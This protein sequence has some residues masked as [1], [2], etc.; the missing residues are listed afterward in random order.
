MPR[1]TL[2]PA[3]PVPTAPPTTLPKDLAVLAQTDPIWA[4]NLQILRRQWKW[5]AFSQF[6]YTFAHLLAMHDVTLVD[7]EDDLARSTSLYLPRVMT[8]L[9]YTLSQD[10]KV[11]IDNWQTALRKQYMKRDPDANPIGPEP[12]RLSRQSSPE[13][14]VQE[15][16]KDEESS[17]APARESSAVG[18]GEEDAAGEPDEGQDES[19]TDAIKAESTAPEGDTSQVKEEPP[20]EQ[21]SPNE[22][23]GAVEEQAQEES[24]DWLELSMLEKLDSLHLLTEWQFQT[25]LRLRQIM[26]DDD[27][28]AK[29]RIEPIGYDAKTNA[30]WLI[31]PDRLWIQRVPPRPPRSLKR[32]RPA[33]SKRATTHKVADGADYV[34][35]DEPNTPKRKRVQTHAQA[36]PQAQTNGRASRSHSKRTPAQ[37]PAEPSGS[38]GTRA[39]KLQANKKLDAQAR[40]LEEYKRLAAAET[41]TSTRAT[42]QAAAAPASVEEPARR[43]PRKSAIM[44]TRASARLRGALTEDD[45]WQPIPDEWLNA[46]AETESPATRSSRRKGKRKVEEV[47]EDEEAEEDEPKTG[48]ESDAESSA[49]TELTELPDENEKAAEETEKAEETEEPERTVVAKQTRSRNNRKRTGKRSNKR[50]RV[51]K[52]AVLEEPDDEPDAAAETEVPAE[53]QKPEESEPEPPALPEDFVEWEAICVTLDEWEHIAERF[54][55]ATHYLEKALYKMLT[56]HVIPPIVT[57]L[58]EAERKRRIEEAIVHRKRSSRIALKESEK[59]EARVAAKRKAE[60]DEKFARVRRVEARAKKEEEEREKRERAREQRRKEREEREERARAKAERAER[61]SANASKSSTATPALN[62]THS[63]ESIQL[64]RIG[65]PNGVRSPDWMLDCEIC[66][67]SGVN[68]DDSQ[69]MVSCGR[70]ARWQHI[71]CHDAADQRLGRPKRNWDIGQ[72]YCSRCRA[73]R[74]ANGYLYGSPHQQPYSHSPQHLYPQ[75]STSFHHKA[76]PAVDTYSQATSD[77]RSLHRP[78]SVAAGNGYPQPYP[79]HNGMTPHVTP[80]PTQFAGNSALTFAHY[81]PEQR[82]FSTTRAAQPTPAPPPSNWNHNYAPADNMSVRTP[83]SVQFLPQYAPPNGG[84]YSNHR[85][86][87]AYPNPSIP[88]LQP[89]GSSMPDN[90]G[91]V[92]SGRWAPSTGGMHQYPAG[93]ST[94]AAAESL[95]YLHDSGSRQARWHD[96][97]SSLPPHNGDMA[98]G[99]PSAHTEHSPVSGVPPYH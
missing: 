22:P 10:R 3:T 96:H 15:D 75:A 79:Q 94:Q 17:V 69:P 92:V 77:M 82:M 97:S 11:N 95:A 29:W 47:E 74:T 32:K 49:L 41:R 25:P 80:P 60:E 84:S 24:K 65:T 93:S 43:S 53:E 26:R 51:A 4:D 23:N 31:G 35:E 91:H 30:Y 99:Y 20:T 28:G 72:F 54:E 12:P 85:A 13:L 19:K 8:R 88:Q 68:V 61:G 71:P 48:L 18:S 63:N 62:G 9:L 81:Q 33:A 59:E 87:P 70:C 67:K 16:E 98:R 44:G 58:R 50:R 90:S 34:S 37:A 89:Y 40:E 5:A 38:K 7:I 76:L 21:P 78:P 45:E 55:K 86:P 73:A 52:V 1:R 83:Q 2:T 6:F 46:D 42:R 66:H 64:S 56:Q 14:S 39:A 57:E 36:Q 27:E